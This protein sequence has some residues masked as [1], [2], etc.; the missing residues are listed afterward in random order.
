M[1]INELLYHNPLTFYEHILLGPLTHVYYGKKQTNVPSWMN[2]SNLLIDKFAIHSSSFF[3]L[4]EGIIEH[5]GSTDKIKIKGYDLFTVN[6]VFR[7]MIETYITFN[8]IFVESKSEY[9]KQFRFYL[10]KIDG[11]FE[12]KKFK[13]DY[14]SLPEL[15]PVQEKDKQELSEMLELVKKNPFYNSLEPSE[16]AKIYDP[17]K[18]KSLW[19]FAIAENNKIR[20]LKIIEL[21][22]QICKTD[23]FIN[24]YKYSSVHS[25]SGF[26][27][28]E[29]FE[30]TRSKPI[31]DKYTDPLT[32]LAIYL[33]ALIIED[34]CIIDEN[35]RIQF[36]SLPAFFQDFITGINKS[37]RA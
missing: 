20:P 15:K 34:I 6:S 10:W 7:V 22:E 18:R 5:K 9:E 8:H 19:K 26:I 33:T 36:L 30:K 32:R 1:D 25:H 16:L 28:I 29:H 4:S 21:V 13:I 23:A 14:E 3:H 12:K 27:S 11:L 24:A 37:I 31:S 2:Y 17:E 35:A